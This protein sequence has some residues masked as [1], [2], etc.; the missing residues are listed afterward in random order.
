MHSE[1]HELARDVNEDAVLACIA[2]LNANASIHG[3]LVQL[4]LP[5]S[6][7]TRRLIESMA[8]DKDVD[9]FNLYN[10]GALVADKYGSHPVRRTGCSVCWNELAFRSPDRMSSSLAR[11][12]SWASR[13][14]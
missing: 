11:A 5:P 6:F 1:T 3:I 7:N 12:T 8:T 10:V 2:S 9:G 14:R 13:W 4:P